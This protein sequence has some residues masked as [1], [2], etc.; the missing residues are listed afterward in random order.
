MAFEEGNILG[1][2]RPKGSKNKVD[3]TIKEFLKELIDGNTDKIT[4]ELQSLKGKAFLDAMFN[5]M[6]YVQPKLS[7][8]E[9]I[10]EIDM[11][12]DIDLSKLPQE[13]I[14]KLLNAEDNED[15]AEGGEL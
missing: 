1:K 11:S 15:Q 9:V 7:R 6:E 8:A 12:D 10:A 2:G 4:T 13:V 5:F 14:D 3:G